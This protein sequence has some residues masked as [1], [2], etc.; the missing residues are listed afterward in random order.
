MRPT[1]F[2]SSYYF[3]EIV[4]CFCKLKLPTISWTTKFISV[5][6]GLISTSIAVSKPYLSCWCNPKCKKKFPFSHY[7]QSNTVF[8]TY[9]YYLLP[10]KLFWT[11]HVQLVSNSTWSGYYKLIANNCR[12]H[13]W[14]VFQQ[15]FQWKLFQ[16]SYQELQKSISIH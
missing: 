9:F 16:P 1:Y 3:A 10:L 7:F 6:S 14:E 4:Q 5:F 2:F 12:T 11:F 13:E 8:L 15:L